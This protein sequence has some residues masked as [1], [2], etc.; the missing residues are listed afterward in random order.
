VLAGVSVGLV[1]G[2]VIGYLR[3]NP[4][5]WTLAMSSVL[6]G[7]LR[8]AYGG[9]QIYP[10]PNNP[11]GMLFLNLYSLNIFGAIPLIVLILAVLVILGYFVMN[12][13]GYGA[14]LKLTGSS[15]QVAEMTGIN[16]RRVIA[17]AF[18]I[19]AVAASVGG[20]LLASLNKVGAPYLGKDYDFMAVTAVVVG[21]MTLAGG[22]G[23]VPGV[24]GGVLVIG[25]IRNIMTLLGMS[26]FSQDIIQGVVFILVVGMNSYYL[27]RSGRDYA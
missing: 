4:I 12:M 8:W 2:L 21:G 22:R 3:V 9:T 27:R 7:F 20:I 11:A 1:N 13:T 17:S 5:I 6:D 15:Y 19:S 16:V 18:V 14:K 25:L 24:L 26:T 23:S 10:D